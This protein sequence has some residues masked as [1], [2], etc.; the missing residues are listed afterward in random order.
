MTGLAV[1]IKVGVGDLR[2]LLEGALLDAFL[3]HSTDLDGDFSHHHF[4]LYVVEGY[5]L[6][7]VVQR[8]GILRRSSAVT[9]ESINKDGSFLLGSWAVF[10]AEVVE[11][12]SPA[13]FRRVDDKEEFVD[14]R[15]DVDG[16]L[17]F[18]EGKFL[19]DRCDAGAN[20][21]IFHALYPDLDVVFV[22][23]G[24]LRFLT[25]DVWIP[26][27]RQSGAEHLSSHFFSELIF[28]GLELFC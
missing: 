12:V 17:C 16:E 15:V 23:G 18:E 27:G 26:S 3:K 6:S 11:E 20:V 1:A 14:D 5:I 2:S 21:R 8:S 22:E 25:D 4:F 13:V 28:D 9:F 19:F 7:L 24:D 10:F